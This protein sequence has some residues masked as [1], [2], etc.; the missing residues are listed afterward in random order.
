MAKRKHSSK[1][2]SGDTA[3]S[4]LFHSLPFEITVEILA[5]AALLSTKTALSISLV[6]T[7]TKTLGYEGLYGIAVLSEISSLELF[8]N[9]L[10]YECKP[11]PTYL[12]F[13]LFRVPFSSGS[14]LGFDEQH[15]K[16]RSSIM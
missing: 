10:G 14:A 4:T 15:R 1:V 16:V 9:A 2:N 7:W 6:A 8:F 3:V 5:Y 11:N 12:L 13:E